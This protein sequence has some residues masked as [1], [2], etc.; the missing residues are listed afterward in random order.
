LRFAPWSV[1]L[2][3]RMLYAQAADGA[4]IDPRPHERAACPQCG[5]EVVAKC[6]RLVTWHW[7]HVKRDCDT[8]SEG[9]SDWHL[10]WK[11]RAVP[12][13]CEV[14]I[15]EHRA[16]IRTPGGTVVELQHS[17]IDPR[18]I[19]EREAFYGKLVWLFDAR[20]FDL[21]L[22][23]HA[24][25]VDF[26]WRRPKKSW[27]TAA[28]PVYWD[29]GSDFVVKIESI[30]LQPDQTGVRGSG[31]LLDAACFASAVFGGAAR[32][33]IHDA[34]RSRVRRVPECIQRTRLIL[35]R[36]PGLGISA[37]FRAARVELAPEG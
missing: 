22:Y 2:T 21:D 12:S 11:R 17:A 15:G 37:A 7:A 27:L 3:A 26:E 1:M 18:Q 6:G 31:I 24:A 16:D 34:A 4:R 32:P 13:A 28:S 5:S 9:E 30:A 36:D 35:Q 25:R 8:W 10:G 19:A 33:E 23:P 29:L 14:V 20:D